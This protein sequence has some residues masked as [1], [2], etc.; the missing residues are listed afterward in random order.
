M[1]YRSMAM[2]YGNSYLMAER[3]RCLEKAMAL[4]ER[5]SR[6]ERLLLEGDYYQDDEKTV[7]Q[8]IEAYEEILKTYPDDAFV[9]NK[10]AY[11][12]SNYSL[13]EKSIEHGLA[14]I[15]NGDRTYFPYSYLASAYEALGQPDKAKNI[16]EDY[17]RDIG[18]SAPLHGEL[19]DYFMY[20]GRFS[21]AL[22]ELDRALALS[23]NASMIAFARASLL[24]YQG[25]LAGAAKAYDRLQKLL[26]PVAPIYSIYG[27]TN[28]AI[29]QGQFEKA[30]S[31]ADRGTAV[32]EKFKEEN[33]ANVFRS[34]AAYTL[35]RSGRLAEALDL[36]RRVGQSG[37]ALNDLSTQRP[38]LFCRG[39]VLC[40]KNALAEAQAV[41]HDLT[42]LCQTSL[43]PTNM[44]L[45]D[46]LQGAIALRQGKTA[47]AVEHLTRACGRLPHELN[48]PPFSLHALHIDKLAEAHEHAGNLDQAKKEYEKITRLTTGRLTFGDIYARSFYNL[49]RIYERQGNKAKAAENYQK[50][51]GLWKD[52]DAGL[53]E[54]PEAKKRL[55]ALTAN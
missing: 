31:L 54:V 50:F 16:I 26:D 42:V 33:F 14:S 18:E 32:L 10:L 36:L 9:H 20:Q 53:P 49:G 6:K 2:S 3:K 13:Y 17:F 15:R 28:L 30:K 5:I 45:A 38:A 11:L 23:P 24:V 48:A 1:A 52:A 41:A 46:H 22:A 43:D 55:A 34:A 19:A 21:E 40:D 44:S 47:S 4:R 39:L 27:M 8:A 51:L 29:L 7:P 37:L 25:D 35:W 12:Y